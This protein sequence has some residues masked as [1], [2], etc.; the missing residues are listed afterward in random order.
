M[1]MRAACA[2]VALV[3]STTLAYAAL[4]GDLEDSAWRLLNISSMDDSVLI[5]DDPNKYTLSFVAGGQ[6]SM[7]ADCNRGSGSWSSESPGQL[8]FGPVAATR[9]LCP[10]ESLSEK[11]LAQLEWVRSYTTR[12]GHLFLATMADGSIIEFEPLPPV[13]AT[14]YGEAIRA[15]DASELQSTVVT[16]VFAHYA[17]QHDIHVEESELTVYLDNMRRGMAAEGLTAEDDLTPEEVQQV[18]AMRRRLGESLIR[19]WKINKSLY[20]T[21]GGRIIYQQ[22]GPEPLD[23]YRQYFEARQ[24]AGDFTIEDPVMA[25]QF[26]SYFTDDSRHV[27]MESVG[28]DAARAF[29]TPPWEALR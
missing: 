17:A 13:V 15:A 18:D 27:F 1:L 14:V 7:R 3:L 26:W 4:A 2:I 22:L 23:A 19:Q 28:E 29:T 20:E 11:Y 6:V 5:P 8:T 9:A 24:T 12:D 25:E 10:P 16:R 21:Y